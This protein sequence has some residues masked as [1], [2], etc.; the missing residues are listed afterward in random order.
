MVFANDT[1][2]QT[3]VYIPK[4]LFSMINNF[5]NTYPAYGLSLNFEKKLLKRD[6]FHLI[7]HITRK[8]IQIQ[9]YLIMIY[10]LV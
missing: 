2:N 10:I 4:D 7:F 9:I 1:I 6:I 5:E 8:I 3:G